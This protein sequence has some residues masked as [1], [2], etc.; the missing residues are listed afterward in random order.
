MAENISKPSQIRPMPTRTYP[1][2]GPLDLRRTLRPLA[3][4]TGDATMRLGSGRAWHATRTPDGPATLALSTTGDEL[5][6]EAWGPGADRALD[7][8]PEL[9]GLD[10]PAR[11]TSPSH[12][13]SS[14][15]SPGGSR[16]SG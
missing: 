12:H 7:G 13:R 14:T 4:G 15:S 1:L 11:C 5:P 16:A 2:D 3:R 9:V 6:A 8:V 10:A